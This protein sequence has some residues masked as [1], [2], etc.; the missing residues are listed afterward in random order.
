MPPGACPVQT[1]NSTSLTLTPKHQEK[2]TS[3]EKILKIED[4]IL[5]EIELISGI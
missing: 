3:A 5:E 1:Y 2:R 4:W